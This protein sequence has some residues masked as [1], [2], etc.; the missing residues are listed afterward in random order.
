[1]SRPVGDR[2]V[3]S[4]WALRA[5][6]WVGAVLFFAVGDVVTTGVGFAVD[7]VVEIG[8][9]VGPLIERGGIAAMV[10]L[11]AGVCVGCYAV[12][13]FGPRPQTVGIPLGLA[14]LGVLVTGWNLVVL[15]VALA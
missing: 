14:T 2:A 8:P 7:R 1:M 5:H 11:K 15:T 4:L 6:L 9:V 10:A 12:Y 3:D 13:R